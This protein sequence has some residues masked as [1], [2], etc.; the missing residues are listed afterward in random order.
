MKKAYTVHRLKEALRGIYRFSN[1]L[2]SNTDKIRTYNH[3]PTNAHTHT[4]T[5]RNRK[6][7]QKRVVQYVCLYLLIGSIS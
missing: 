4:Q 5:Q 6:H 7:A 3:R 2:N 1:P